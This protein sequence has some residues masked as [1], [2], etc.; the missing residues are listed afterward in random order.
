MMKTSYKLIILYILFTLA[1]CAAIGSNIFSI[2]YVYEFD[3]ECPKDWKYLPMIFSLDNF[4]YCLCAI[5][6]IH[7]TKVL[8]APTFLTIDIIK[9]S[10]IF[11]LLLANLCYMAIGCFLIINPHCYHERELVILTPISVFVMFL[12]YLILD[13]MKKRIER[14]YYEEIVVSA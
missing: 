6:L 9:N 5:L 7:F 3:S 13:V 11:V 8:Y 10:I 4:A 12:V 2:V 14:E 1:T